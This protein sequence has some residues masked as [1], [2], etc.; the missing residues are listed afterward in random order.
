MS[1]VQPEFEYVDRATDSIRYLEHGWPTELCRWHSHKEYE[2]H[3]VIATSGRAFVGDYIG[4]FRAGSLFLIGPDV[5]HNWI[6]DEVANPEAVDLRDMLVQ[7]SQE[8]IDQLTVAFPEFQEMA[9]LWELARSGI[10][11]VGFD[12]TFARGHLERIRN[13]RGAEKIAAFLRFLVRINEHAEKRALSVIRV[14]QPEGNSKQARIGD[15]VDFISQNYTEEITLEMAADMAG[16]SA[17]AFSRNFQKATGNKFIEFVNRVRI[18]QACSLLYATDDPVS[19][20][21]YEVGFQNLANFN[22]H[23]LK[24][25]E[26]PP[27]AYRDLARSE[28]M[29]RD[30]PNR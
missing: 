13:T 18:G 2:L 12:A 11:F 5:P 27:T 4:D 20:I 6:T 3:L 7:F 14:N 30:R 16:M 29:R 26:M 19:S 28:L 22:R 8:S 17:P 10:E 24:M 21:C 15:V 1:I 25:K 23:F 9:P